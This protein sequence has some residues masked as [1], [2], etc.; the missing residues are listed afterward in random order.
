MN[1]ESDPA[2]FEAVRE[3]VDE[4]IPFNRV[5]GVQ[6]DSIDGD[7]PQLS[8]A[9][10]P[11]LVGNFMR[12]NL[13]GGV[14]SSVIDLTGGITALLGML[15]RASELPLAQKLEQFVKLGTIDLRIDYLRP[16]LG[17][18]FVATGHLLRTGNKVAV[19]RIELVNDSQEL[20]AVGTGA[21]VVA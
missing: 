1:A 11:E 18:R 15:A 4:R 10:Q 5:L 8:F 6:L 13:H 9:M 7:R 14:I 16:G 21:Y 3:I 19:A 17:E 2:L 12:G 20:I